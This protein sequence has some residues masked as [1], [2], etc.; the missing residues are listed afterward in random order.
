MKCQ[1]CKNVLSDYID[2]ALS[3]REQARVAGHVAACPD[4]ARME[5][6]T[7]QALS[8]VRSLPEMPLPDRFMA[9]L[10]ERL[11]QEDEK[12]A[13]HS[14]FGFN[15]SFALRG[16]AFAMAACLAVV[17]LVKTID[18]PQTGNNIAQKAAL[19]TARYAAAPAVDTV[20]QAREAEVA[21]AGKSQPPEEKLKEADRLEPAVP[22]PQ[23]A[24]AGREK[25][26]T[27][28]KRLVGTA[29]AV[30][31]D[32]KEAQLSRSESRAPAGSLKQQRAAEPVREWT[33]RTT[34][35][36]K[37][38][39]HIIKDSAA[40][41]SLWKKHAGGQAPQIDFSKHMV[42]AVFQSLQ[43]RGG[44]VAISGITYEPAR[45]VVEYSEK[46]Q[47][48]AKPATPGLPTYH[49][50]L[51]ERSDLPVVFRKTSQ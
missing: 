40:W 36:S 9:R 17:I 6:E 50:Q 29:P 24:L 14:W 5:S 4:C 47:A 23:Q 2:G 1:D 49:M 21:T 19:Q 18:M 38:A 3:E 16:A 28:E 51:I 42:I 35:P 26:E 25:K 22:A 27:L 45:I 44:G 48:G 37:Q 31:S 30:T 15:R 11:D 10:Q 41:A 43:T 7:R 46:A 33:G 12:Q 34:G 32:D 20:M 13:A 39:P 8:A